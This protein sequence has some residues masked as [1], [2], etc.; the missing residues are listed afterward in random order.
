MRV[1]GLLAGVLAGLGVLTV[2]AVL[3]A[4]TAQAATRPHLAT[5]TWTITPGPTSGFSELDG[6]YAASAADAWTVGVRSGSGQGDVL[7]LI[8]HWNGSAWQAATA[9]A[10][11]GSFSTELSDVSGT[12]ASDVWAVG[13]AVTAD[14]H[15][16]PP[17]ATVIMHWDGTSWTQ[18]PSPNSSNFVT[19]L[20]RVSAFAPNDA[21]AS[22]FSQTN[23]ELFAGSIVMHWDG[24]SWRTVSTP[25]QDMSVLGGSSGNDVWFSGSSSNWHWNGSTFTQVSGPPLEAKVAAISSTDQWSTSSSNGV[26]S[27][28]H[29][30]GHTWSAVTALAGNQNIVSVAAL[31]STDVWAVGA[32]TTDS[33]GDMATLTMQWNGT[34]WATVPSPNPVGSNSNFLAGAA[35]A[36]PGTVFAVGSALVGSNPEQ[37]LALVTTNG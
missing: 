28:M 22:G 26:A 18:V 12:S 32:Q 13:D 25:D 14:F 10:V 29:W 19:R 34:S 31:S 21:W 17:R 3:P 8:E 23:G 16:Y 27:L 6:T 15:P 20:L 1:I 36:A 9:P 24:S 7:P 2:P 5:A 30:N 4:A 11:A 35:A 33:N 37:S